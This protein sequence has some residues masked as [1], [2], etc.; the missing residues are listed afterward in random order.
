MDAFLLLPDDRRR[1][2]C[3]EAGRELSLSAGSVEKD[4][5][6]CWTLKALFALPTSGFDDILAVVADVERR[7]NTAT[8]QS[9]TSE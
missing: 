4:F 2:L 6:V 5:W 7:F 3:E 1:L 9:S 8:T